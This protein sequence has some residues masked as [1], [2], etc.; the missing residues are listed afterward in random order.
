MTAHNEI[1][2]RILS[3]TDADSIE[4]LAQVDSAAVPSGSLLGAAVDG[5]LVAAMA[6]ESGDSIADPFISS[7]GA[8]ALLAERAQQLRGRGRGLRGLVR[9]RPA[10]QTSWSSRVAA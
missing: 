3:E 10:V 7:E 4:R 6:V 5:R 8:R 9:R 2:I 1:S